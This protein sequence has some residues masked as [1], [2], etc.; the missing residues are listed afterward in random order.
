MQLAE[1]LTTFVISNAHHEKC[2]YYSLAPQEIH[3]RLHQP[4]K[5]FIDDFLGPFSDRGYRRVMQSLAKVDKSLILQFVPFT[6]PS[7]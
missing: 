2:T 3:Q 4:K 1:E 5:Q 6:V 7:L